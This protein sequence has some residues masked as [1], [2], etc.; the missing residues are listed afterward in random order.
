MIKKQNDLAPSAGMIFLPLYLGRMIA[1]RGGKNKRL[2]K[3]RAVMLG[4]RPARI[5]R[6]IVIRFTGIGARSVF[7]VRA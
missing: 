4:H 3:A 2:A 6:W 5:E 7:L 1:G